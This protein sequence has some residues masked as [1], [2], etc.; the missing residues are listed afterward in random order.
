MPQVHSTDSAASPQAARAAARGG[1]GF[2]AS[3]L[4]G[5]EDTDLLEALQKGRMTGRPGY[6]FKSMWRAWLC[7]YILRVRY[8]VE[9][10]DRLR[11]S[12]KLREI[13]GFP[14]PVPSEST[15]CR[16]FNR[17]TYFQPLVEQCLN[18]ITDQIG[19]KLPNFGKV[20]ATDA[21]VFET[22]GNPDRRT[23]NGDPSGDM[24]ARWGYKNSVKTKDKEGTEWCFGYRMHALADAIYGI[25]LGFILTPANINDTRLL[26]DVVLKAQ[27]THQWLKPKFLVAD[28]GYDSDRNFDFLHS[29]KIVP[30]IHIRKPGGKQELHRDIYTPRGSPTCQGG[31]EMD[32][33]RTDPNTRHHLF[34]CPEGGCPLKGKRGVHYCSDEVWEN[35]ADEPRIV[36]VLPRASPLWKKLY[37]T[38]W[39]IERLFGSLK[40]SRNLGQHCFRGMRKVLLHSTLSMLTYS[41]TALARLNA[42]DGRR[43]RVMRVN[44][45]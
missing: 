14:G 19:P 27:R 31:K 7:K 10:V 35:P 6:T 2:L 18:K 9:L 15:F 43:M 34:R 5:I 20:L 39:S 38:R 41:A 22:Y 42:G 25:P 26:P 11:G 23:V 12:A 40:R 17:L 33:I 8:N 44:A 28:R 16:F 30:V 21:T 13:C 24:D 36:G 45:P 3:V 37:K 1:Y 29:R 32:Y 4:D